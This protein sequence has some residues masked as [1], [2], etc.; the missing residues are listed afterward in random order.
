[1]QFS[2][3]NKLSYAAIGELLKLLT[4]LCP[5]DNALPKLSIALRSFSKA[6]A[7]ASM[8]ADACSC[9]N[10]IPSAN[11]AHLVTIEIHDLSFQVSQLLLPRLLLVTFP[12]L[13]A[14]SL[15]AIQLYTVKKEV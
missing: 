11:M 3:S 10:L 14:V 9:E 12:L 13:S 15:V 5:S 8:N 6:Y 2:T 7:E 1:M 4:L